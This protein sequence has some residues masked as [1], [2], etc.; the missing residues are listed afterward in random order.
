[1]PQSCSN[2]LRTLLFSPAW[3]VVIA[4]VLRLAVITIGHTY[5][6]TPRQD[7]FQFGW[8]MGRIA[9]SI[10]TGHGFSSPLL[11][12]ETGPSAWAPPLYPYLLAGVFKLFGIYTKASGW[13]ILAINSI[14]SALT[15]LTL[16]RIAARL[17]GPTAAHWAAWS[18]A[19]FPYELYWPARVVWETCL[20]TFLLSLAFL[21]VLRLDDWSRLRPAPSTKRKRLLDWAAFGLLWGVIALTNTTMLSFLPLSLLWIWWHSQHGGTVVLNAA[22]AMLL[23]AAV[24]AP[25]LVRNQRVFGRAIFIRDNLGL[26]MQVANNDESGGYWTRSEHPANDL[27]QLQRFQQLGEAG[28]MR[29]KQQQA[30]DWISNHPLTFVRYALQ[31]FMFFWIGNPQ[32]AIVSGLNMDPARHTAFGIS[33]ALA[34]AGLMLAWRNRVK[35]AFLFASLMLVFPLPYCIAHPAPRYRNAIEP[36]MVLLIVYLCYVARGRTVCFPGSTPS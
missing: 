22:S 35:G 4:L 13:V 19:L 5:K 23:C 9:R 2:R 1:M 16:Y 32:A 18:W 12:A 29:E 24:I 17:F 26:E 28:Y 14:F 8:E 31:R 34:F 30:T 36:E 11:A 6:I 25:W 33:A 15:C 21:I 3:I 7:H 27:R 10:A 20:S